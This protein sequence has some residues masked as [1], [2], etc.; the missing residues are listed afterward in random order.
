MWLALLMSMVLLALCIFYLFGT[1]KYSAPQ[2][3]PSSP[4]LSYMNK[5]SHQRTDDF[6]EPIKDSWGVVQD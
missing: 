2:R 6:P 4:L 3:P 5:R 1:P